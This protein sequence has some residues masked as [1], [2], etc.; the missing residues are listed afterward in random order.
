MAFVFDAAYVLLLLIISPWLIYKAVTTGKYR[1][2]VRAK[3]LG[4]SDFASSGRSIAWFHGVSV[5]EIHLLRQVIARFRSAHPDW[6][7]VVSS[8]TDT[9]LDEARK[10]FPDLRIL[11]WPL[12]FSWGVGRTL[13]AVKPSLLVLAEGELW[14]NLLRAAG[15][16]KIPVAV[17]NARM[18]PRTAR[19]YARVPGLFR[20]LTKPVQM[21]AVQ[22]E[23]LAQSLRLLGIAGARVAV[24]GSVKYDGVTADRKNPKTQALAN[25]LDAR[26]G[27]LIWIAGSTQAPEEEIAL[28]IYQEARRQYPNLRLFL[29]PRQKERF[30]EVAG[31]LDR[32]SIPYIRRSRL[33]ERLS[34]RQ[35]VVL[36]DTIGEL[37]GL[38]GLADVAF[39]G[40]SMDGR[41]GGQNMIE[42]A[43]YGGA[44]LFGPHVWNFRETANRLVSAGAAI[45]VRDAA[46]LRLNVLQLLGSAEQRHRLGQAAQ[47]FVQSQQ[48]ATERT[49]N[50]LSEL[51]AD[52]RAHKYAA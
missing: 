48:G 30:D 27:D 17:I 28:R 39:V 9:G 38:W 22:N 50:K 24:T 26:S 40:G 19:R 42:P 8:T 7:C 14:P 13:D 12:D 5:G 32:T 47:R 21:F 4:T 23:E 33:R 49:I 37:G 52:W 6:E 44:V 45:Q 25:L 35:A 16:R 15:A 34:D 2:N 29:V 36:L 31:L 1:R 51:I 41:R 10:H 18:S 46:E 20:W 11:I 43:A 3:F